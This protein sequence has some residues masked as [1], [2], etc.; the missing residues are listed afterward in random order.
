MKF[1]RWTTGLIAAGV[2][3]L[4][5]VMQAEEA[6]HQVLTA[7]SSTTLSGYVDTSAIWK[8]GTGRAIVGNP[9]NSGGKID[10]FNL[11]VVKLALEKPLDEGQWSA[12]YKAELL[13]GP[14]AAAFGTQT[15]GGDAAIKQAYVALRAPIGNGLD[16]KVGVFDTPIGYEVFDSGSNPNYSRSYGYQLEPTTYTGVLATYKFCEAFS[17]SAGVANSVNGGVGIAGFGTR[18]ATESEKTYLASA[19]LTAPE[20]MGFLKGA[21]LYGG[22]I[23]HSSPGGGPGANIVNYY[24]GASIPLPITGVSLGAAWDYQTKS[25]DGAV[26]GFY[27]S[28]VATY[29]NWQ[30][31]EKLKLNTRAEYARANQD[32]WYITDPAN[33]KRQNELFALTFTSDYSLWDNVISRLEF[34]WDSALT[35]GTDVFAKPFGFGGGNGDKNALS[36]AANI[37]YKF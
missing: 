8:L 19:T 25:Q 32:F 4:P 26:G 17:L 1:N 29:L 37:I 36:V 6:S 24:G 10:S 2:I 23:D 31:T 13:F 15:A 12:G 33:N 20:S 34:R 35:G 28:A 9:Y 11:N 16:F 5:A 7:L 27:R 3:S 30:A 18:S 22:I 14:D 21:S